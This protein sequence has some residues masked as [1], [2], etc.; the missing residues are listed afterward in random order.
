MTTRTVRVFAFDAKPEAFTL[1]AEATHIKLADPVTE[2]RASD[3]NSVL[4]YPHK[5]TSLQLSR[6]ACG[7][8]NPSACP[9]NR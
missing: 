3:E 8:F 4:N 9:E 5:F 2:D 6:L 1:A 7:W